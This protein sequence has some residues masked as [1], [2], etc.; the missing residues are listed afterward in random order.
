MSGLA[1]H[2]TSPGGGGVWYGGGGR[3][4]DVG[5]CGVCTG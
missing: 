2:L 4:G 1:S 3:G 5:K